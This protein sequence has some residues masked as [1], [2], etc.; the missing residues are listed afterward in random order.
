MKYIKGTHII[1]PGTGT[2]VVE[3]KTIMNPSVA[4]LVAAGYTKYE[5]PVLE[6]T[7]E[8]AIQEVLKKIKEYDSSPE[9]NTFYYR[10]APLWIDIELRN[11]LNNNSIPACEAHGDKTIYLSLG[12]IAG[13][14][15]I[16]EAK[17]M[18]AAIEYYAKICF[19]VTDK[20]TR[21]VSALTT[22]EEVDAY[23]FTTGY[24]EKV[25]L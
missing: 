14:F 19:D 10:E 15:L 22:I 20:H 2:I 7:L 24:P 4:T 16:T 6:R 12:E 23:D 17:A 9:V 8:D 21:N 1:E 5:A 25:K 3:N 11:K 13:D 18:L